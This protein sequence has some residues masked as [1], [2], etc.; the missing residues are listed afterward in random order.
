MQRN[1]ISAFI[2]FFLL[3]IPS[4]PAQG[5][6]T[7]KANFAGSARCGAAGFSIGAK[8]YIGSG[9]DGS[10]LGDF[11]EWDQATDV[12][13]QR[14]AF[15]GMG[16]QSPSGF[17]IGNK[18]YM[19]IGS[20]AYPV[21]NMKK[22]FWEYDPAL[23]SW[24]QKTDFGGFARYTA[25]AFSIGNKGYFGTGWPPNAKDFWEYDSGTGGWTQKA[26]FGGSARQS[27]VGFAIGNKGYIGTGYDGSG[28]ND[29]WEYDPGADTW[30]PKNNFG[31][32]ARYGAVGFAINNKGYIGTGTDGGTKYK[33]FWEYDPGTDTWT[34]L[35]DLG[36]A[37]RDIAVGFS[38]GCRG[39]IGTG[40]DAGANNL[41]DFWEYAPAVTASFSPNT[42][43]VCLGDPVSFINNSA[44]SVSYFWDFGV[45]IVITDTSTLSNPVYVYPD[46]GVFNAMLIAFSPGN[47]TADTLFK[48]ITVLSLPLASF[49][50]IPDPACPG[51]TISFTNNSTGTDAW[52]WDFGDADTSIS[53]NPSQSFDFAG[54][55]NVMLV[56]LSASC[57]SDTTYK[58]VTVVSPSAE[59]AYTVDTCSA[60]VSFQN[61]SANAA[62]YSWLFGDGQAS[63]SSDPAHTFS[64]VADYTV[65]LFIN[66]GTF[67]ADSIQ[68]T[69]TYSGT[70][71][72]V[73]IPNAFSPNGDGI[74]D[75]LYVRGGCLKNMKF[76]VYDRW[77]NKV[78]E[79]TGQQQGWDG[80]YKEKAMDSAVFVYFLDAT[81]NNGERVVRKG[82]I[83]LVR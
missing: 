77:G 65:T 36:G 33:D 66:P 50:S 70:G 39:Y 74:N 55:Y 48:M 38:V 14:A 1:F 17:T 67:C 8:G 11:W 12:W 24:T 51:D 49:S 21:Y 81:M 78:F 19:G 27:A 22:D 58:M 76:A 61:L 43:T 15:P 56:S 52:F 60:T 75:T 79:T 10:M 44:G 82:N 13:T 41:N 30:T 68:H 64:A 3:Q 54:T 73:F 26:D 28:K 47:C 32:A 25:V 80:A 62:S 5:V 69:L 34:Q 4:S 7:Q 53:E 83:S 42:D 45:S 20:D 57:G 46:T 59:F 63:A 2:L 31:G 23:N 72:D 29:F 6:W 40:R 16:R 71:G 9:W 18:G 35:A 37:A